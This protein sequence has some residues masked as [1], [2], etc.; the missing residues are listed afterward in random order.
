MAAGSYDPNT[1]IVVAGN[2]RKV[3]VVELRI[4]G[5]IKFFCSSSIKDI[6]SISGGDP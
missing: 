6:E 2:P 3:V 5:G 1:I 4:P